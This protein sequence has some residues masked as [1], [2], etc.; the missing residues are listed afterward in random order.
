[1]ELHLINKIDRIIVHGN[2]PDGMASAIILYDATGIEPEFVSHGTEQYMEMEATPNMLF[3][4]IAPPGNRYKEF[5]DA[6]AIVLD[7]HKGQ[8][9][10]VK[11]F[12]KNGFFADEINDP[13]V[14]GAL[15]AYNEVWKPLKPFNLS[16]S[17]RTM[18]D[19]VGIRDT[20]LKSSSRWITACEM[21]SAITFFNWDYW[22][23][24][25]DS[26]S[27]SFNKELDIGKT[28]YLSRLNKAKDIANKVFL[29]EDAGYKVAVFNDLD[30]HTSDVA[31]ILRNKG[32]NVTAG[33]YYVTEHINP[34]ICFSL[35]SDGTINVSD[36]AKTIPGGGGHSKAAGFS[37]EIDL[38]EIN[39]FA[40]FQEIFSDYI[41]YYM[42]SEAI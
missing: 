33:F 21:T 15:L 40:L 5:I 25:V 12:G 16:C 18:A 1:M 34:T 39:P 28:I 3:C 8:E 30:H 26:K 32:I 13:G 29:F 22:K 37:E 23:N 6:G 14:S 41:N 20:F 19:L 31:D 4:D 36:L 24:K 2:C 9:D 7:H 38:K 11:A 10:I 27:L 35:R 42:P 17:I